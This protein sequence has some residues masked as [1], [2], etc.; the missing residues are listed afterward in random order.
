MR[1]LESDGEKVGEK[2][3]VRGVLGVNLVVLLKRSL[4]VLSDS[5]P[6]ER[7]SGGEDRVGV[8]G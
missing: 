5:R 8:G 7:R 1:P 4:E 6:D 3:E 2:G